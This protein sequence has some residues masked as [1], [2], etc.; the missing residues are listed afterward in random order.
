MT[1]DKG[2]SHIP[3]AQELASAE[4]AATQR[5][6][7]PLAWVRKLRLKPQVGEH[8]ELA[9]SPPL[10]PPASPVVPT[11]DVAVT[12]PTVIESASVP[13]DKADSRPLAT[14]RRRRARITDRALD[15]RTG[16]SSQPSTPPPG[17]LR[18]SLHFGVG[19]A[20]CS[21]GETFYGP[22]D[23]ATA[24]YA[25]HECGRS[26]GIGREDWMFDK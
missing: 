5:R 24:A 13:G 18:R 4:E 8:K 17:A 6:R 12:R 9:K 14:A 1:V 25:E 2:R 15:R 23:V 20:R 7:G 3:T 10:Y 26:R 16:R 19:F 21:C 11:K 22:P